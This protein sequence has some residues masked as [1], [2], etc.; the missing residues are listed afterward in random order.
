MSE[1]L[2][3]LEVFGT[4]IKAGPVRRFRASPGLPLSWALG[5]ERKS[6]CVGRSYDSNYYETNGIQPLPHPKVLLRSGMC[7]EP[8]QASPH[9]FLHGQ[10]PD[11]TR[12]PVSEPHLRPTPI[13]DHKARVDNVEMRVINGSLHFLLSSILVVV[14]CLG[15]IF[16]QLDDARFVSHQ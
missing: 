13:P 3:E 12:D 9:A 5:R 10:F 11:P 1:L 7:G 16:F 15:G 8:L 2:S 4:P 14:E 6:W